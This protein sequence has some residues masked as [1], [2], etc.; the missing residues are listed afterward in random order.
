M[1]SLECRPQ[2]K[3]CCAWMV[4]CL[5]LKTPTRSA[6]PG[7]K[8]PQSVQDAKACMTMSALTHGRERRMRMISGPGMCHY[9]MPLV[10]SY[11]LGLAWAKS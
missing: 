2:H 3:P 1:M 9:F 5:V 4:A 6:D 11:R 10:A 8:L 7:E